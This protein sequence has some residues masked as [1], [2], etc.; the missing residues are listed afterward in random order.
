VTL[1]VRLRSAAE[2]DVAE[3]ARYLQDNSV[4]AAI[5]FLDA[6]DATLQLIATSPG[7]GG[8]CQ[9]QKPLFDKIRVWPIGGFKNYLIF[10]RVLPDE[11]EVVRVLHGARDLTTIF[12]K[13]EL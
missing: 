10:Y 3:N 5:R 8:S 7:I 12:G 6:F 9:F 11:I 2:N 1:P 4:E 13:S